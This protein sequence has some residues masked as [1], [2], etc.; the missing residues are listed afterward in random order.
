MNAK[1]LTGLIAA[2]YTPFDAVGQLRL[3]Q[4][5]QM[6]EHLIAAGVSGLY[7]CG[8]TGEGMS[9]TSAERRLVAESYVQ[10]A[11]GRLPVIIQVGHNS[12][13]EAKQLAAHAQAIGADAVSATCPSYFKVQSAQLLVDC[14]REIAGGAPN[15]PFYYYHI[16]VLTGSSID[17]AQFMQLGG[18]QIPNLVG[19]KY[20]DTKLHEFQQC[21]KLQN[22]RFD[23]VWGCDEM[24]LGAL[25]S[26]S[27]G[28]IGSTYN[29][30]A[31]LYHQ[32][33]AAFEAGDWNEARAL[34]NQAIEMI[35]AIGTFPFH[36]AMKAILGMLGYDFGDCRLPQRAL[37]PDEKI[38]LRELLC[39]VGFFEGF[40]TR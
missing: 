4:T 30:A 2:T 39:Q 19:L 25:A 18:Q 26:G 21:L 13:V 40:V 37:T 1:R 3:E 24:L 38:R 35:N 33:I 9:L 8:S 6:V 20:T 28:A 23:V 17:I 12:V 11:D 22:E 15:L 31:P 7:V 14:M 10:A 34:Q 27:T 32:I 29:I 5:P 36:S 16:P